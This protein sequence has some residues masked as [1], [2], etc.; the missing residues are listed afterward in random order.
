MLSDL[1][2]SVDEIVEV[3][4]RKSAEVFVTSPGSI[5]GLVTGCQRCLTS[6]IFTG[7]NAE[8][9]K[10]YKLTY[11]RWSGSTGK[12]IPADSLLQ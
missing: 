1:A 8:L 7:K 12:N 10:E 11:E 2:G 9:L 4:I 5:A 6:E 3:V